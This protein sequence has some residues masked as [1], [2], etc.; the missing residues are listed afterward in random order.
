MPIVGRVPR[1]W[2]VTLNALVFGPFAA[3]VHFPAAITARVLEPASVAR[4][5]DI[6]RWRLL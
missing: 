2:P 4:F 5:F 6:V 1:G 3:G